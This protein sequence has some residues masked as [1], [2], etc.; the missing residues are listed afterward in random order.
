MYLGFR[1]LVVTCCSEYVVRA[2]GL[3]LLAWIPDGTAREIAQLAATSSPVGSSA[4]AVARAG[5]VRA[6]QSHVPRSSPTWNG[7]SIQAAP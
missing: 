2:A 3:P 7:K 1:Q 5:N 4:S 6:R